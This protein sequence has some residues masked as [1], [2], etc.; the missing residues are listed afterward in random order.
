MKPT[1]VTVGPCRISYPNLFTAKASV[2]F[3]EQGKRFSCDILIPKTDA[4]LIGIINNAINAAIEDGKERLWKGNI[5]KGFKNPLHDGDE[6]DDENYKG[7]WVLSPWSSEERQPKVLDMSL[8]PILDQTEVYGGMWAN[9]SVNFYAYDNR[10]CG[11]GCGFD[12]GVQ[13]VKDDDP[14]GGGSTSAEEAFGAAAPVPQA[15]PVAP[16]PVATAPQAVPPSAM[17]GAAINP[18]TGMPYAQTGAVAINPMTGLP[19]GQ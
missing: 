18:M 1:A 3:P 12:A 10:G 19:Y 6:R 7:C 13:K 15:V 9:V 8:Q 17:F 14:F 11:V 2:K 16:V 5:P 4:R